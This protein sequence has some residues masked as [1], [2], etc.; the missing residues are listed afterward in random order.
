MV[1]PGPAIVT[2]PDVSRWLPFD[3][4]DRLFDALRADGRTIIGPVVRDEAIVLDEISGAGELPAGV[5]AEAAPGRYRLTRRDDARR[6]DHA[7]GPMSPKRFTFPPRAPIRVG[8]RTATGVRF[9]NSDP[10]PA[11]IALIGV[12]ACEL[13]ALGVQ[14][15]VLLDGQ[16]IDADYR[17]RRAAT[18]IVA[19][20][21]ATP[22]ST[23]FCTSM[24]TGPEVTAGFDIALTELDEGYRRACR[25]AGRVRAGGDARSAAGRSV[26]PRC[27]LEH[28][29]RRARGDGHATRHDACSGCS[30]RSPSIPAGRPWRSAVSAAPT[31]RSSARPASARA[32][33]SAPTWTGPPSTDERTWDSLLHRTASPRSP[34]ARSARTAR[35]A[36]A[37]G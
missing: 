13:A 9:S 3:D 4:L 8:R 11:P 35:I 7:V 1:R 27:G 2:E 26:R 29:R 37:S 34:A 22:T 17:A 20:E 14:D 25:L 32:S 24:G 31:A 16:A 6:F 28:R 5:G 23:C 15:R 36:T 10:H 21:C 12:R 19:V 33:S 30:P 18:F